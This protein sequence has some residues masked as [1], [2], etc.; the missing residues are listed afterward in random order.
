METRMAGLFLGIDG[1]GTTCRARLADG[2]GVR[3]GEGVGGS[4]NLTLGVG[5]VAVSIMQASE[6]AFAAAG[7]GAEAMTRTRAGFGLAGANV[8]SLADAVR[9]Y[10]FPFAAVELASD[11]VAACLGA[12]GGGDGAILIVGTGSQG[13]A[14]VGGQ[15]TA[16]GGWGFNVSD[17]A[18]GAILGRAAIRAAVAAVDDL[19]PRSPLTEA[20]L[21]AVGGAP[22]HAVEWA[23]AARPRDYAA[24]VPLILEHA[25]AG[26]PVAETLLAEAVA[27]AA[28]MLDRLLALGAGRIA[29]MG[30]L[31]DAYRP[32]LPERLRSIVVAPRGDAVD[33]AL[34]LARA[35]APR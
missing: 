8:P 27:S 21:T 18:S 7:L 15:A 20:L 30:G 28:T 29:L 3:L 16:I 33:G 22:A 34:A 32:H 9:A 23:A 35:G 1:G 11:A 5:V 24:F 2:S 26:D 13:L 4:A 12:H 10:P 19:A 25:A 6:Q 31:A 14:I 17:D